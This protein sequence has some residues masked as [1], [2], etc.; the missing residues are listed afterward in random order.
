VVLAFSTW[1]KAAFPLLASPHN[2]HRRL[3]GQVV[4]DRCGQDSACSSGRTDDSQA[5]EHGQLPIS[6]LV[7][8]QAGFCRRSTRTYVAIRR[9]ITRDFSNE[10][11]RTPH[12]QL[13][14]I[15]EVM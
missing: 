3:D 10:D 14:H 5:I 9:E 13:G 7:D 11:R 6:H 2:E 8:G 1:R 12:K 15:T 4:T